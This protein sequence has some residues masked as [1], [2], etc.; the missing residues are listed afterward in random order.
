M[1][2]IIKGDDSKAIDFYVDAISDI[3]RDRLN[4]KRYF[5]AT[6]DDVEKAIL[7]YPYLNS[8]KLVKDMLLDE[9]NNY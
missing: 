3:K 5:T 8:F 1:F 6:L 2:Y 7:K 9:L 4:T